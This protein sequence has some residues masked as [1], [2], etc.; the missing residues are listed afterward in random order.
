M[1]V[2]GKYY[3]K[4][5][6]SATNDYTQI[7]VGI[8]YKTGDGY[9]VYSLSGKNP[10]DN[11]SIEVYNYVD[12]AYKIVSEFAQAE[13]NKKLGSL[14][15]SQGGSTDSDVK[16]QLLPALN[17]MADSICKIYTDDYAFMTLVPQAH[18][19]NKWI[20]RAKATVPAIPYTIQAVGNYIVV[21]NDVR[22]NGYKSKDVWDWAKQHVLKYLDEHQTDASLKALVTKYLDQVNPGTT[23]YL[24]YESKDNSFGYETKPTDNSLWTMEEVSTTADGLIPGVVNIKNNSTDHYVNVTGKYEAEPDLTLSDI[25]SN[26]TYQKNAAI[27]LN[28]G[29]Y[30]RSNDK[31]YR[32]TELSNQGQDVVGY[33]AKGMDKV[34]SILDQKLT[35]KGLYAFIAK[36]IN[37]KLA[38]KSINYSITADNVRA[39]VKTAIDLCSDYY[40]YMKLIDNGDNTVSL[41]MDVPK[42]PALLD[43]AVQLL[44]DQG[45]PLRILPRT[46]S[47]NTLRAARLPRL[48][49]NSGSRTRTSG[50]SARFIISLLSQ[51]TIPLSLPK[52][53]KILLLNGS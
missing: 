34:F 26:A 51:A 21:G 1:E 19:G 38:E 47:Q 53:A 6:A 46:R 16:A 10:K 20:V 15:S 11:S 48:S 14:L 37:G 41:R 44:K 7:G 32:I 29:R 36:T 3:A 17:A 39:D 12:K 49:R 27:T 31:L 2:K 52:T 30:D 23:Y 13:L 5:D 50:T 42:V 40:A 28:F 33:L 18:Y 43:L 25:E 24:T 45:R 9:R 35:E 8:G 22:G 4:P